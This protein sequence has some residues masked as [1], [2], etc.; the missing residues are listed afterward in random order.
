MLPGL[1]SASAPARYMGPPLRK[2]EGCGV[3]TAPLLRIALV[4]LPTKHGDQAQN[5]IGL[6]S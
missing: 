3:V 2:N 6:S 1:Y 4:V 5:L